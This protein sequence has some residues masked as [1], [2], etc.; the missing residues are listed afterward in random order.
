MTERRPRVAV[1]L[2]L[3]ALASGRAAWTDAPQASAI[4]WPA[5]LI[6]AVAIVAL[7]TGVV[8]LVMLVR[9]L[10]GSRRRGDPADPP[11]VP[12]RIRLRWRDGVVLTVVAALLVGGVAVT[13]VEL[14]RPESRPE[15]A[16][17]AGGSPT[18]A[19]AP[20]PAPGSRSPLEPAVLLAIGGAL[21]AGLS[22]L[23]IHALRPP[24]RGGAG[25]G[26]RR[27]AEPSSPAAAEA[28]PADARLAAF[29]AY[30]RAEDVLGA[31]GVPRDAAE[32]PRQYLARAGRGG[33]ELGELTAIYEKARFSPHAVGTDERT[34]A[35]GAIRRLEQAAGPGGGDR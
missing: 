8:L 11:R 15:P 12:P 17:P 2:A 30:R 24:A 20:A 35:L 5:T 25:G 33:A 19:A 14:G 21:V 9:W 28:W 1:L 22:G 29:A 18:P 13:A 10:A 4:A 27:A 3:V 23:A 6:A 34:R 26:R 32:G 16:R 31:A 7:S